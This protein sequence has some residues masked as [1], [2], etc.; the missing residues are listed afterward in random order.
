M[1]ATRFLWEVVGSP[2]PTEGDGTPI[3]P[4]SD[5]GICSMCGG[6][7]ARFGFKDALSENFWTVTQTSKLFP[8]RDPSAPV[9]LCAACVWCAKTLAL[10][11]VAWVVTKRGIWWI[12]KSGMLAILLDP[13][14][15]PFAIALPLYGIS[16]GGEGNGHRA[17]WC[18]RSHEEPLVKLQSKHCAIYAEMAT[19]RERYPLQIDDAPPVM[20]DR[21]RWRALAAELTAHATTLRNAGVGADDVR[22]SLTTLRA[23][24]RAPLPVLARWPSMVR[25]YQ[26]HAGSL[27]WR[28]LVDLLPMPPLPPKPEKTIKSKPAPVA[29]LPAPASSPNVREPR[30]RSLFGE[31]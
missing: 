25:S 16:H 1:K 21:E 17:I 11:C 2:A 20:V 23:P 5:R 29:P 27:W 13:P 15:P 14:E 31:L 6:D 26:P 28:T 18:G 12:P 9:A 30:Q 19:S 24:A 22:T 8:H 4:G 3:S 7:G 10:R